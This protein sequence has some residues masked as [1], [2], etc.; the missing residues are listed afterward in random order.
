VPLL[1]LLALKIPLIEEPLFRGTLL[2]G[3]NKMNKN[4]FNTEF[5]SDYLYYE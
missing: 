3:L 2:V 4:L 1:V 5:S